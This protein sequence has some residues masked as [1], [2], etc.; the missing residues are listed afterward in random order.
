MGQAGYSPDPI[1]RAAALVAVPTAVVV[2]GAE[3]TD[4][5]AVF[6]MQE[7]ATSVAIR[8]AEPGTLALPTP[9]G[10]FLL[11]LDDLGLTVEGDGDLR[12]TQTAGV[13]LWVS[14]QKLVIGPFLSAA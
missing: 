3:P 10:P 5:G 14:F 6:L 11:K 8:A 13:Q 2:A 12:S 4:E 9:E 1:E 7:A